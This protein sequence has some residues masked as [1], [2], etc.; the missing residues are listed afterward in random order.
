MTPFATLDD[1][2]ARYGAPA[3]PER[4]KTLLGDA[5]VLIASQPGFDAEAGGET[6]RAALVAV[7]CSVVNRKLI[8]GSYSGFS[9]VS[10][11]AG[12][13]TASVAVYNPSGDMFLTRQERR[14]LGIGG[15]RVGATDPYGGGS[16]A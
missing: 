4:T 14:M 10:Q 6:R 16:D 11:G 12:G 9:S 8:S 7:T 2:E 15:G 5:S 3:D 13:Q 1:Y